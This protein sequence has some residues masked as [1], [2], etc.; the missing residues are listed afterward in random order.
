LIWFGSRSNLRQ[1]IQ[2]DATIAVDSTT[3][4]QP[5]NAVRDLG[6]YF[7]SELSM[8]DHISRTTKCC[9]YQLRRL[10]PIRRQ[11]GRDVTKCLVCSFVL[12]RLDYCNAL[13]AGL[14]AT[15]LKP[16]QRVQNAAA[17]LVLG[18]KWSDH[19]TPALIELHWLP[20]KQRID[21][22]LAVLVYKCLH[23]DA[24]DYLAELFHSV[25]DI[26]SRSCLRSASGDQ[27]DIPRSRLHF[28]ERAF[29]I[30]GARQW[31]ALPAEM[32]SIEDFNIFKS[33]LKTYLFKLAFYPRF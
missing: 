17:R 2:D 28:G 21:Y 5:V 3:T 13:L 8:R 25:A 16:L 15:T 14:P 4:I 10:R 1:F 26:P 23:H 24:P 11:L 33:K 31:N 22:K 29:A 12:S 32:R 27:L 6:F 18:L 9:F 20:I 19:I 7:D 30:A